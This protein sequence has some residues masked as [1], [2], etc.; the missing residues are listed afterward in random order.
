MQSDDSKEKFRIALERKKSK[1]K[2]DS[3]IEISL[4]Q[5][6]DSS[7]V[8]SRRHFRRKSGSS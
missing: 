3:K 2:N 1:Q 6:N 8:V 4:Q 7:A 5:K